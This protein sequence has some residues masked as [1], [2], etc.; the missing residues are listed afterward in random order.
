MFAIIYLLGTFIADLLKSRRRLEVEN[1][2]LRRHHGR[3]A[4]VLLGVREGP[5][6]PDQEIFHNGR[7]L[8]RSRRLPPLRKASRQRPP[9]CSP[10]SSSRNGL[11]SIVAQDRGFVLVAGNGFSLPAPASPNDTRRLSCLSP[12]SLRVSSAQ[13]L[14]VGQ[15]TIHMCLCPY[16]LASARSSERRSP[17]RSPRSH[18]ISKASA[19]TL[20]WRR[21]PLPER[22]PARGQVSYF[23]DVA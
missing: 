12:A 15:M 10:K 22:D 9:T 21:R 7:Y 2:F 6:A 19:T 8:I 4:R 3:T 11:C 13:R 17:R 20:D 23:A 14:S 16:P 5:R 1:L 18:A